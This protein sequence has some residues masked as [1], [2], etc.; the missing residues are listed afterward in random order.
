MIEKMFVPSLMPTLKKNESGF[1]TIVLVGSG[2]DHDKVDHDEVDHDDRKHVSNRRS[3]EA[4]MDLRG[5]RIAPLLVV[6]T[7]RLTVT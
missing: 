5:I 6:E 3:M 4:M 1:V 7:A 2:V